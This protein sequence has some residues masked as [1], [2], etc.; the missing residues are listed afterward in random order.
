MRCNSYVDNNMQQCQRKAI[1][2]VD[3]RSL[4][5]IH[6]KKCLPDIVFLNSRGRKYITKRYLHND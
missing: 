3:G 4:C 6:A 5:G 1:L 2:I